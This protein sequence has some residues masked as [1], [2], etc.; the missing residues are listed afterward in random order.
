[1]YRWEIKLSSLKGSYVINL[2]TGSF[3]SSLAAY[4]TNELT[5]RLCIVLWTSLVADSPIDSMS[6]PWMMRRFV[7]K[8]CADIRDSISYYSSLAHAISKSEQRSASGYTREY[9]KAMEKTPCFREYLHWFKTGDPSCLQ[10]VLT[11]LTFGKKLPYEDAELEATA[12]RQ[13]IELEDRLGTLSAPSWLPF[14]KKIVTFLLKEWS[15]DAFLPVHGS[16]AV[17]ERGIWGARQKCLRADLTAKAIRL[18]S[19]H[20][21]I[22]APILSGYDILGAFPA[23]YAAATS[24]PTVPKARLTFVPKDITKAR[25]ICME[26]ILQQYLQQGTRLWLEAAIERHYI[27]NCMVR[28]SDQTLNQRRA[29]EGSSDGTLD[30]IDLSNASDSVAVDVVKRVFPSKI[31]YWLLATRSSTVIL[32]GGTSRRVIKFAPMGSAL[33]FPVQTILYSAIALMA[34]LLWSLDLTEDDMPLLTKVDIEEAINRFFDIHHTRARKHLL[35]LPVVYGDDIV[36]DQRTT[37]NIIRLL[38]ACGLIVN[39]RKSFTGHDS[40]RESCGEH[41][42]GGERVTPLQ[43]SRKHPVTERLKIEALGA[44]IEL[45]NEAYRR[46]MLSLR[47]HLI[48]FLLLWPIKD[49]RQREGINPILFSDNKDMSYA[50]YSPN[51]RNSHLA[52]RANTPLF[53]GETG[54]HIDFQRREVRRVCAT[55]QE[56]ESRGQ[57][58]PNRSFD[59]YRY[60]AWWRSRYDRQMRNPFYWGPSSGRLSLHWDGFRDLIKASIAVATRGTRARL[61]WSPIR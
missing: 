20:N 6:D 13:W 55:A 39:T 40:Y 60:T 51:P 46:G 11:V 30:T 44:L 7:G 53:P 9:I 14:L 52:Q 31:L 34:G 50:I 22:S 42:M 33:C 58:L 48:R 17:S 37:S 1:M 19:P 23:S 16:G 29:C 36:C 59:S 35:S 28:L 18:V 45:T 4:G 15:P 54:S 56:S 27:F 26:P 24:V 21:P 61:A 32:P 3:Q 25:S 47:Q 41:Y 2:D 49:I 38:T 57:E 12:L 10:F 5:V 8:L 43:F